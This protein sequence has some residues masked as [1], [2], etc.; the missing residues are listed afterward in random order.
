[1]VAA[2]DEV[3][4]PGHPLRAV[5]DG[6]WSVLAADAAAPEDRMAAVYDGLIGNRVYN[7]LAWGASPRAYADFAAAA[8]DSA[9]GPLLDVG[10][11]TAVFTADAYRHARRPLVLVDRSLGMLRRAAARVGTGQAM[12]VQ[13]DLWDLPSI[14]FRDRV[15]STVVCYGVLHLLDDPAAAVRRLCDQVAPGGTV[16]AT[17]LVARTRRARAMLRALHRGGQS[18]PPRT[19]DELADLLRPVLPDLTIETAGAMAY[20]TARPAR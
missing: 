3:V 7:R 19:P 13:A 2:F 9:R 1:M 6:I 15:F 11:G 16:Y 12:F 14:R 17:A 5:G 20:L 4:R 10:C 18:A 8:V